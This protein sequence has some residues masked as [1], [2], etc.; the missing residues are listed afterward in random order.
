MNYS[1]MLLWI[2]VAW[3]LIGN[4]SSKEMV[5]LGGIICQAIAIACLAI[6]DKEKK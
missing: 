3:I 4:L 6:G 2:G 1:I 5:V